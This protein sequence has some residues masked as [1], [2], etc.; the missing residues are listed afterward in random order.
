MFVQN[1]KGD[2][3]MMFKNPYTDSSLSSE[4]KQF[5]KKALF[6]FA[7]VTYSMQN[8]KFDF[9]SCEDTKFIKEISSKEQLRQVPLMRSST[10]SFKLK[11]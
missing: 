6:E 1:D 7:K 8:K 10:S 11:A 4:E 5:L 3:I 9:T 2:P